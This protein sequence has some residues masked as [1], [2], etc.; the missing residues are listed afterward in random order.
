MKRRT[1]LKG[2]VGSTAIGFAGCI[3]QRATP[4]TG[5]GNGTNPNETEGNNDKKSGERTDTD[6]TEKD[7]TN[8]DDGDGTNTDSEETDSTDGRDETSD[9]STDN[10]GTDEGRDDP[11]STSKPEQEPSLV[12][13]SFGIVSAGCGTG[14]NGASISFDDHTVRV[15][16]TIGGKNSCYTAEL[17]NAALDRGTLTV[18]VRSFETENS[19][20]CAM[21]LKNIEYESAY[22]FEDGLPK[23]VAVVHNGTQASVKQKSQ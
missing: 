10:S 4:D 3:D 13:H 15:R 21:C 23:R 16:G 5:G 11:T 2:V 8:T 7:G 9:T 17:K 1:L 20:V 18:A 12:V 19:G 14:K 22:T 6:T